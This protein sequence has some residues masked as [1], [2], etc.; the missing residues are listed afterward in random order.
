[1]T[2]LSKSSNSPLPKDGKDSTNSNQQVAVLNS[3]QSQRLNGLISKGQRYI[4]GQDPKQLYSDGVSLSGALHDEHRKV[5]LLLAAELS[6]L[7]RH[8]AATRTFQT[9]ADIHDAVDDICEVFPSMKLDEILNCF[10][11]IRRGHYELYG[12]FTINTLIECLR[13]YE[14]AHTVVFREEEHRQRK[15]LLHTAAFDVRRIMNDLENDG[16]LKTSRRLLERT[17]IPY[18]NDKTDAKTQSTEQ[19]DETTPQTQ[20]PKTNEEGTK[21]AP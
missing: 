12:N 18:P 3:T 21:G 15:T 16:K 5:R 14:M 20:R 1:M 2:Q 7:V 9:E 10:K 8:V 19:H 11:Y 4:I 13:K 17:Y 6:R